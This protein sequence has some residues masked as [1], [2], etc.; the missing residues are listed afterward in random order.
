METV[1]D[2]FLVQQESVFRFLLNTYFLGL[3]FIFTYCTFDYFL[4]EILKF[5]L[6][7]FVLSLFLRIKLTYN[8]KSLC[9]MH[10]NS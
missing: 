7:C 2:I 8:K 6:F 9:Y 4:L 3:F 10:D 1:F 5:F